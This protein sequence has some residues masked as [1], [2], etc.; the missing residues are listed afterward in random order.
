MKSAADIFDAIHM[1]G[2]K[3]VI[4]ESKSRVRGTT[5][6]DAPLIELKANKSDESKRIFVRFRTDIGR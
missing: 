5:V 2:A 4:E 3:I 6:P 1:A